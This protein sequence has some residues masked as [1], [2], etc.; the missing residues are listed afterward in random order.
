MWCSPRD[1]WRPDETGPA[2]ARIGGFA[3]ADTALTAAAACFMADTWAGRLV[4]LV[5]LLLAS[6]AVHAALCVETPL[7]RRLLGAWPRAE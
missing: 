2:R 7:T 5:L 1:V 4:V 6:V 3:L